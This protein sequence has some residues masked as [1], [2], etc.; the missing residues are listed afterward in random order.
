MYN[1]TT[2]MDAY[3]VMCQKMLLV[4]A[5]LFGTGIPPDGIFRDSDGKSSSGVENLT[6]A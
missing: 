2:I 6:S 4:A 1:T 5:H 3:P